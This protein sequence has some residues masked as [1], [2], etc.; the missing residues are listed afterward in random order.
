MLHLSDDWDNGSDSFHQAESGY[1]LPSHQSPSGV[2]GS[3]R[4]HQSRDHEYWVCWF[5]IASQTLCSIAVTQFTKE[6]EVKQRVT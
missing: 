4:I 1:C 2:V 6:T 3:D 5:I